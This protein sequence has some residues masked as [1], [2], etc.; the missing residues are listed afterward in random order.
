MSKALAALCG[1]LLAPL[2]AAAPEHAPCDPACERRAAAE[3]L[4]RGDVRAAIERLRLT[5]ESNPDDPALRLWL[6][7]GYLLDDNL[8]WAERTLRA[9]LVQGGEVSAARLWLTCVLL[10]QGDPELAGREL[11]AVTTPVEGAWRSRKMLLEAFRAQLA[12]EPAAGRAA[13]SILGRT[14]TLFTEDRPVLAALRRRL[15]PWWLDP[16][17]GELEVAIG[18]TSNALAGAPTDPGASG[19]GSALGE[20]TLRSR[21]APPTG[22]VL[23][24]V[25]DLDLLGRGMHER[26]YRELSSAQGAARF[27]ALLT[28]E[29]YRLLVG[30]R[31]ERLLLDQSPSRYADA[32]RGELEIEWPSGVLA[33]A[34]AGHRDYRDHDRTRNEWDAG[35]GTPLRLWP[36][37]SMVLG[38]TVRGADARLAA[39]DLRGASVATATRFGLGAGFAARVAATLSWEDYPHSGGADGEKVF[40][41]SERR[42]DVLGKVALGLWLPSWRIVRAG[43]EWQYARRRSTADDRPGF[44]FSYRESRVRVL[45][46]W[47][48]G[49]DPRAPRVV[50]PPEHVPLEWGFGAGRH[51]EDERIIELLRHDEELRRGS[52]CGV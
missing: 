24:P 20:V 29:R 51:G 13:L 31:A 49:A 3:M 5:V 26:Q 34:G 32:R 30:V 9:A 36:G 42:R 19:R 17:S 14:A 33:F 15:D 41:T 40:G 1:L 48:F 23:R 45:L 12:S 44:D 18:H 16:V 39:Y 28:R 27:G 10:R 37:V 22:H 35:V 38:A 25:L 47:S 2:A 4:E 52:S 7:R 8:F 43:V 6:A 50:R 11:A 21:I 46:R